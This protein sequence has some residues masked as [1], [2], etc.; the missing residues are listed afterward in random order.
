VIWV[1]LGNCT[2]VQVAALLRARAAE[3]QGF[4]DDPAAAFLALG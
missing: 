1:R 2:T 3:V 4:V